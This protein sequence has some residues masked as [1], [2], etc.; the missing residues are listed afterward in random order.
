MI[1]NERSAKENGESTIIGGF[2]AQTNDISDQ[3][4]RDVM[5][6]EG[7]YVASCIMRYR[8]SELGSAT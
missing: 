6:F 7:T 4:D 5:E 8:T 3:V 2:I 1:L